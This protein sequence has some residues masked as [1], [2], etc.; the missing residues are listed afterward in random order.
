MSINAMTLPATRVWNIPHHGWLIIGMLLT[1]A[2]GNR[3]NI[4]PLAWVVSV[5]WLIYL[6]QQAGWRD[7]LLLFVALQVGYFFALLKITTEPLPV[8]FAFMFSIPVAISALI[9]FELFEAGRRRLGDGWGV[10]L[11]VSLSVINEWLGSF[12]SPMGSWGS[13]AYSQIDNLPLMQLASVTGLTGIS[14]LIAATSA[15]GAVLIAS[16]ERRRF[17]GPLAAT[18]ALIVAVHLFGTLRIANT[19][20]GPLVSVGGVVTDGWFGDSTPVDHQSLQND[21]FARSL[22]AVEQGAELVVWN[23]AATIVAAEDEEAFIAR[24]E[25]FARQHDVDLVLA[26]GVPVE[27]TSLFENQYVW[28]T[29]EGPIEA[30][31]KHH[32]VPNE[33]AVPGTEPLVAHDRPYGRAAGAICYD[34]DFPA[35]GKTHAGLGVDLVVV[36]SSDWRGIDPYHTRMASIRGIE[37]GFSVVRPVWAATS[38]AFDAYGRARATMSYYEGERVFVAKV[39]AQRIETIYSQIGETVPFIAFL[40]LLA[41]LVQLVRRRG[42]G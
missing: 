31:L 26:F 29:P 19:L 4:A 33:P 39:P 12:T 34:Y 5:P 22:T 6:R 10:A 2:V 15:L 27:G 24:G 7:H 8:T 42:R 41:V 11:F 38:G 14:A 37:G 32:P 20:P 17:V 18:L 28:I 1:V 25:Q 36:P 21:L 9:L 16:D 40:G 35:M 13:I 3:Y 30:Y 23:E